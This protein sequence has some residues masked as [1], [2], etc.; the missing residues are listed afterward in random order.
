MTRSS[1]SLACAVGLLAV[2][3]DAQ[4][5]PGHRCGQAARP[6]VL[7]E[8]TEPVS[9]TEAFVSSLRAEL[10][11]R[12]LDVCALDA[13]GARPIATVRI[14]ARLDAVTLTVDVRDA[15]TDKEVSRDVALQ[16]IPPDGQPLA[17]AVAA[18]ELLRA[19][20]AEL[21]LRNAP[22]P[23]R[24][25][26]EEVSVAV[27]DSLAGAPPSS[28]RVRIGVSAVGETYA[29]GLTLY[30][31]DTRLGV[32]V[33]RRLQLAGQFGLRDGASA[34]ASDGTARS[35]AWS[36]AASALV[37]LVD[38]QRTW[39]LDAVAMLGTERVTFAAS[40]VGNAA[41]SAQSGFAWLAGAGAQASVEI[42]PALRV[43]A[44][45]LAVLPLRGVD[46]DDA[47]TR[48]VGLS[49]PGVAAQAGVF[50]AL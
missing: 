42:V 36:L 2:T 28:R 32:F 16:D 25:V 22:P 39:G 49:G 9:S 38:P 48:F 47:H 1:I 31:V 34:S 17:I 26:P 23:A 44:E 8:G 6:W 43:G 12:G 3:A 50:G 35:T 4:E 13:G 40:P 29:H 20:W 45:I 24:P 7:V 37:A 5:P 14:A 41:A 10:S 33:A 18:D 21:A 19:S 15:V 30:G 11:V 27:R 46:A